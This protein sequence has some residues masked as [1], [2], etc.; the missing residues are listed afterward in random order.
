MITNSL[1]AQGKRSSART[2]LPC[3]TLW[4][5]RLLKH[6]KLSVEGT[7][8]HRKVQMEAAD[9]DMI[10]AASFE[11]LPRKRILEDGLHIHICLPIT[12]KPLKS[13]ALQSLLS[14]TYFLFLGTYSTNVITVAT[15]VCQCRLRRYRRMAVDVCGVRLIC[16][17][18][19]IACTDNADFAHIP[20]SNAVFSFSCLHLANRFGDRFLGVASVN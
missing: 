13:G 6:S 1:H 9:P 5:T 2:W 15:F 3:R 12:K 18:S 17:F 10:I 14:G 16:T 11:R 20:A 19:V 7:K 8:T 4:S